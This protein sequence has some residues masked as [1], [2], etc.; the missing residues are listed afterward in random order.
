MKSPASPLVYLNL[1]LHNHQPIGNFD[2]VFEQAYQD[3]YRPFLDLYETYPTLRLGLH[4]SGCL[5]EWLDRHHPDYLDR[6]AALVAAGRLEIVGGAFYEPIL[7][8][9]PARDR[10]G[11]IQRFSD[12]LFNRLGARV[13]GMWMPERVWE[14][15]LVGDLAAAGIRYTLLDDYHFRCAGLEDRQLDGYYLT[16]DQ[17]RT[18]A[19]FPGS[20]KLR[21][22]IPFREPSETIEWC[23]RIGEQRPGSLLV[24][25]DDGEKFGTWP[26]TRR[27]VY[28]NGWLRRFF[29]A[30]VANQ[31][32]LCTSTPAQCLAQQP[33]LARI[34]LPDASYREMTEWALP[35]NRQLVQERLVHELEHDPRW[36]DL[37]PFVRGGYWR[38]FKNKYR[39]SDE[40][41]ARMMY[42]SA[43][44]QE[45]EQEAAPQGLL[46]QARTWLYRAQC[47]CSYWHGAFGGVYLPHLRNAVYQNLI[48]AENLLEH[49]R[50][51]KPEWVEASADDFDFDGAREIRLAND[52]L[53]AWLSPARG[54]QL[55]G[56]DLR[57]AGHNLLATMQRREEAYH[58][59]ITARD[60]RASEGAASI[61]DRV[62]LKRDDLDQ[63]LAVDPGP[64]KSLFEHFWDETAGL[65]EV[66]CCRARELG[67]F[68]T[69]PWEA[70]IRRN[71]DRIQ[72]Y[73][74][75][76]GMADGIPVQLT[77]TVTLNAGSN[78]LELAWRLENLPLAS[79]LHFAIEFNFAGL[80]DGQPDR[81]FS[82][83]ASGES[84]GQ[85]GER[86]DLESERE[87]HLHDGWLGLHCGL[88]F[89][90]PTP[91]WTFPIRSVSG[92]E[93]GFE[94]VH[95]SVVVQPH[96]I[97][98]PDS[99][100]KWELRITLDLVCERTA[101]EMEAWLQVSGAV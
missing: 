44:L 85:L 40:M 79:R 13:Q 20:E 54:G 34:W 67:D 14:T 24:F 62:V 100:G 89:D 9:I 78:Q 52:Q 97:V 38:N 58:H 22:L 43:L 39:E 87:L 32:W 55:Y 26:E 65:D 63:H 47:N 49:R 76:H 25:G 11:Q 88:T 35:V 57:R 66:A 3:S 71:P 98:V 29:D 90:R 28:E 68:S 12:W 81:Y 59:K 23:R 82:R 77:K 31:D 6:L 18:L 42:V 101:A 1:V 19:V 72:V 36:P 56:L 48:L 61:H 80:P 95:Q 60:A 41:Y 75:R 84:L 93:A 96:W 69:A 99:S 92:S 46:D 94:L 30:L 37:Q 51:S 2:S 8:M 83:T 5:M 27:H 10:V 7:T 74:T 91:V 16:E 86:L 50:Q 33:P 73:L 70:T 15:S 4:T 45:A 21:Y 17:G 64:R 53:V